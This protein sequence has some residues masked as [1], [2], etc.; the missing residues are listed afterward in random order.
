MTE[1]RRAH[2]VMTGYDVQL[3]RLYPVTVLSLGSHQSESKFRLIQVMNREVTKNVID[4]PSVGDK[5]R[6]MTTLW[7]LVVHDFDH[8]SPV[9]PQG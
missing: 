7:S 9:F 6:C 2:L 4:S 8:S 5:R 3:D 1:V